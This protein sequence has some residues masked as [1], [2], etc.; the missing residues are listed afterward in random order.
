MEAQAVVVHHTHGASGVSAPPQAREP[1]GAS[2]FRQLI[3]HQP[4][5]RRPA[6]REKAPSVEKGFKKLKKLFKLCYTA[7]MRQAS[8]SEA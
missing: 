4:N 7:I 8:D 6:S 2:S 3:L 1:F 5:R